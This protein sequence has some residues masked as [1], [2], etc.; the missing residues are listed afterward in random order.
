MDLRWG[1]I[2]EA[3][4]QGEEE[5]GSVRKTQMGEAETGGRT[6]SSWEMR[7]FIFTWAPPYGQLIV[8]MKIAQGL[9]P[10]SHLYRRVWKYT[11][12]MPLLFRVTLFKHWEQAR[13]ILPYACMMEDGVVRKL[14]LNSPPFR[15]YCLLKWFL[16]DDE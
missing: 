1:V 5:C 9:L 16:Q 3:A 14:F 15:P 4:A 6:L 8:W 12:L 7:F 2:E 10:S 11:L 13:N